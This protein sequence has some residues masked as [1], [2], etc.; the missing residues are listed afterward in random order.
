MA[1]SD[2]LFYRL[3]LQTLCVLLFDLWCSLFV[4]I[5]LRFYAM[6][7]L[8]FTEIL[9][10]LCLMAFR[11]VPFVQA[12]FTEKMWT[13][14]RDLYQKHAYILV[15]LCVVYLCRFYRHFMLLF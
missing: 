14:F 5:I 12:D 9:L 10:R 1:L 11:P 13:F 8:L 7:S 6:F 3:I 15:T 4:Y 2:F